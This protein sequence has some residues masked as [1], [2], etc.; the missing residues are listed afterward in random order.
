MS[1]TEKSNN[2]LDRYYQNCPF[3]KPPKT[4]KK[5][6]LYNG[7]K[8]KPQRRCY[9]T[10]RTGAE[11]HEIWGGPYRQISIREGFQIDLCPELHR[12]FH[13]HTEWAQREEKRWQQ[14]YQRKYEKKLIES[15]IKP[16]HA[17]E[18]WMQ[19]IGRNYLDEI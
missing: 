19:L 3:P 5:R 16:E 14:H 8:G 17:R 10:G 9:Y 1:R 7:Y 18:I 12:E 15:G 6:L 11:R 13:S 2:D 4:K